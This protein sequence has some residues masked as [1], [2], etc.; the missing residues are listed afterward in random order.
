MSP[1]KVSIITVCL[2]SAQTIC[3]TIESVL[4]QTYRNIEYIIIDG[5]STDKTQDI[6]RE[7]IQLFDGRLHYI[8]EKDNGIYDAMN[9]GISHVTGDVIGM[10]NS[11][12]WYEPYAVERVVKC[13]EETDAEAVYGEIW[14]INQNGEREYHTWDSVF[15]PH[16]ATF[17]KREIY[18][19]YGMFDLYYRIASDREL[20]L[21]LTAGGVRFKRVDMVLANFRRTGISN[22]SKL[23]CAKETYEIDLKYLE[24]CAGIL[25]KDSIEEKFERSQ[26][27]YISQTKPQIIR[28]TL[29]KYCCSS[30]SVAVFGAGRC[31]KEL[32][33]ILEACGIPVHLFADNDESKWELEFHG[34]K[35][36]SPE[37][38][39]DFRGHVI[40]TVTKFQQDICRQLQNYGNPALS[41]SILSELRKSAIH[42][43]EFERETKGYIQ[44]IGKSGPGL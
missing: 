31:G 34:I 20:L 25:C 16:P 8:S 9:K 13:F 29:E 44:R 26:L 19:Q 40:V 39:R 37:I 35:I 11:D 41:W 15:P 30:D 10:I 28:K 5:G 3:Q 18:Q 43:Y 24:R 27:L 38:L 33:T 32:M 21:R 2:N 42:S 36:Y 23:E 17:I 14:V 22:T 6:I 4:H 12:D 7:Y 1:Y